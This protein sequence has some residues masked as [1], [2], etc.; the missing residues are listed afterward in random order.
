MYMYPVGTGAHGPDQFFVHIQS[1]L[2]KRL[3]F[4][5]SLCRNGFLNFC[6]FIQAEIQCGPGW[7]RTGAAEQGSQEITA[8]R[9]LK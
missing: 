1:L 6:K 4:L 3:F 7:G 8:I 9:S 2:Y 5:N